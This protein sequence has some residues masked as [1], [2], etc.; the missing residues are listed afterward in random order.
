MLRRPVFWIVFV[1]LSLAAAVFTF[2]NFST[3]FPLV[4]IDLQ[5]DRKDALREARLLAQKYAWPPKGFD[6]A[7][8]FGTEQEVQNFIELEGGGKPE[9]SR[10]LKEKIYAP[11]TWRV[12]HFKEG[13]AHETQV[14]FTPEG[15]PYGFIVKLPEQEKG[16]SIPAAEAHQIAETAAKTDWKIDFS[17]YKLIESSKD[18]RPGGRTDHTFVY[19]REDERIREGRFRLRLIV[20]GDKLTG[21]IHFVQIPEA[22]TRRYE[23]LRSV[24]DAINAASSIAVFGPYLLGF[25]GIGL[26][27]MIRRHWVIWR[28][29]MVWGLF[30]ALLMGL[31]Q[32][33]SWPLAWMAYDTAVPAS[34]FAIRQVMSAIGMFGIFAV[35]LTIT[36]MAAETLSRRA[37]PHHL[38]LWK[39]WKPNVASSRLVFG[40]TLCGFLLVAPFFAYEI[41]LY[42]FAQEK[43]GWWT[44]SDSLVNPD[45]FANYVPSLSAIA[46]AA[47]AG[48]WEECLFRAA[49]LSVAALIGNRFGKRRAFIAVG[50]IIQAVVFASGHAGY[51]N[52]PAYARVVELI[53]PSFAFGLLYLAFGLLPGIVL[54][55]TYDTTWM[56]LPLFVSSGT[57]ARVEQAIVLLVVLVPLW[58]VLL[59]R[60][61]AQKWNPVPEDAFNGAWR[62]KT[63][64]EAHRT[65]PVFVPAATAIAPSIRIALPIAGLVGLL[66]WILASPFRTDAPPLEINRFDAV[67]KAREALG[68]HGARLDGTWK[69]LSTVEGQP[70]E[71]NRFVW[72]TAG[73][74]VYQKL[75]GVYVTPPS[76]VVRFARW[77]GD[78]AERAEEYQAYIDGKG[79][80][81][82]VN[83]ELPEAQPGKSLTEE[84][85][86][87]IAIHALQ[88]PSD[89]KEISAEA[90][91]RPARTDWTFT[92]KD[93]RDYG[94]TQGEPRIAIEIDGDQIVDTIRFVFVPDEWARNERARRNI[95]NIAGIVCTVL[96]VALIATSAVVGIVHWSRKRPFSTPTFVAVFATLFVASALQIFNSWPTIAAGASTTQPLELQLA[97][98]I[99]TSLIFSI[100]SG[101]AL[102]L[103]AGLIGATL[104]TRGQSP[105]SLVVA[106]SAGLLIA[107]AAALAH[108]A[109]PLMSPTWGNLGPVS[110]FLSLP[111]SALAPITGY[112]T[113]TLI[114]L[115]IVYVLR[116]W[117]NAGWVWILAGLAITGTAGIETMSSWLVLGATTGVVLLLAYVLV[118]RHQ[119]ALLVVSV[120]A[121]TVLSTLR[122]GLQ[123]PFPGALAGSILAAALIA[124]TA[125]VW[126]KGYTST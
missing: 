56:A 121:L 88:D 115:T 52:Q 117:P 119:P 111:G 92:F 79:R 105:R 80:V 45:M 110:M 72:Q 63:I 23:Q 113:E 99:S 57:R 108:R 14:R 85:A 30:I 114:L 11:Y 94:L 122:D 38:Q 22:F 104:G 81:F 7:A 73:R 35:L 125:S 89:F 84:E 27:V 8:E 116:R 25:C 24:N 64:P 29:P 96:I 31:Q 13:D 2:K 42:F 18:D 75:L 87:T 60:M 17:R 36:F 12:R 41:V 67:Q 70:G 90:N 124:L 47:Q 126:Y 5:M 76:W 43:L 78:V 10:I 58:V 26:F 9:L 82:R 123:H 91:K 55:F 109:S 71:M 98:A 93:T 34:G 3:A 59:N 107:G 49:P 120:A 106:L 19:E 53:I 46:Q 65:E 32:L 15:E 66:A 40:E 48:F 100:F 101:A 16:V 103:A 77:Q 6:Q 61:R 50:M 51:A 62:P 44:P 33:N 4:S 20:G 97:I 37:F 83:H 69:A 28:Q 39:V 112:F 68:E 95:P 74:D 21:L 1:A 118:F 54:H 86:R 102:A